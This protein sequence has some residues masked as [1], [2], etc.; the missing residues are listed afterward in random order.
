[1]RPSTFPVNYGRL[2]PCFGSP[3]VSRVVQ[4]ARENSVAGEVGPHLE[5][6]PSDIQTGRNDRMKMFD[7]KITCLTN[8]GHIVFEETLSPPVSIEPS[9]QLR[10]WRVVRLQGQ[11]SLV[12]IAEHTLRIRSSTGVTRITELGDFITS[13]GRR[14]TLLGAPRG[15]LLVDMY[16]SAAHAHSVDV[17]DRFAEYAQED[18]KRSINP[19]WRIVSER[20]MIVPTYNQRGHV[21]QRISQSYRGR[22]WSAANRTDARSTISRPNGSSSRFA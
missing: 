17:T 13:S 3:G 12:G 5:A 20:R 1:M 4:R 9:I 2:K 10:Y 21:C 18:R 19:V 14:Y 11:I 7:D 6:F 15:S 16:I 8:A 22:W